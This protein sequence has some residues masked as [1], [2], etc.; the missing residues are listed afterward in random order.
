MPLGTST[1]RKIFMSPTRAC[2]RR[3]RGSI[4]PGLSWR[5]PIVWRVICAGCELPLD[6]KRISTLIERGDSPAAG[7]QN[8]TNIRGR[9]RIYD[10]ELRNPIFSACTGSQAALGMCD[11]R[12]TLATDRM[13]RGQS[14]PG[15]LGRTQSRFQLKSEA[16]PRAAQSHRCDLSPICHRWVEIALAIEV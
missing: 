4:P 5:F 8:P 7:T 10:Y 15:L 12:L 11:W 16:C 2:F 14:D 9:R 6:W 3:H 13:P 1:T